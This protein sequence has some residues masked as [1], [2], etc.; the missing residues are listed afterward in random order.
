[1]EAGI[2]HGNT[3]L[4]L[5]LIAERLEIKLFG[6]D[7]L[8]VS[9]IINKKDRRVGG[10]KVKEGQWNVITKQGVKNKAYQLWR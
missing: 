10:R 4:F 6:Y 2:G 3:F 1:M 8:R 9:K 7:S 5:A